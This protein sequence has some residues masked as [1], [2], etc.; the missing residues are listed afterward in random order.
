MAEPKSFYR[1]LDAIL[2]KI[3][4]GK[5]GENFLS[6]ILAELTERFGDALQLSSSHLYELRGNEFVLLKSYRAFGDRRIAARLAADNEAVRRIVGNGSFIFDD[7]ALARL[8]QSEPGAGQYAVPAGIY[9]HSS[10]RQWLFI[11]EL[12]SGWVREEVLLFLNA[13]RMALN[14]RLFA[15]TLNTELQQA[16]RIQQSLLPKGTPQVNGY[17]IAGCS[18]PAELV[19]GDFYDF[20]Q[21]DEDSF[22]VAVGDASGHGLV[23][24]LLTRDVVVGLRMGLA[25]EMRIVHTLEKL[26]QVMQAAAYPTTFVSLFVGEVE[27]DGHFFYVNAGHPPPFIVSD[28]E[29]KD[30]PA[31]GVPLGFLPQLQANRAYAY[32]E[33]GSVL[34]VYS[35]GIIERVNSEGEQFG[36]ARLKELVR[37]Q[38]GSSAQDIV[39][40]VFERVFEFGNRTPWEDDATLVVIKR[41]A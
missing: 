4:I 6:Q 37:E 20:F 25:K 24:A 9:V 23:A 19:G 16:A 5:R 10:D 2:G 41:A 18:R 39:R 33:R 31:T 1:E 12:K 17:E 7:P 40:V 30:L 21:F 13:V 27:W 3:R 22:G 8:L 34:V 26:N 36:I 28:G 35:D 32:L 29:Y 11:F 14:Y 15:E 38:R